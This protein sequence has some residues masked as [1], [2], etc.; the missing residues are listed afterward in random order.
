MAI[1]NKII[2][3]VPNHPEPAAPVPVSDLRA[4]KRFNHEAHLII[5]NCD[6]GT[7]AYGR[8]YNYS[9]GGLYFES[10]EAFRPGS[11]VRVDIEDSPKGPAEDH[12]FATV[13][14]CRQVCGAVVLYD[15]AVGL[16]FDRAM[17]HSAGSSKLCII[18]GGAGKKKA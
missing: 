7:Y 6:Y 2:F 13:K 16:E 14:W 1:G 5:Q 8:M 4:S 11:C 17:N 18:Q 12:Y 15:F 9:R 3:L 10:D